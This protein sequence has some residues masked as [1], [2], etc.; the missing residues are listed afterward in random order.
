VRPPTADNPASSLDVLDL[1]TDDDAMNLVED[2]DDS[3]YEWAAAQ[4]DGAAQGAGG[5][6]T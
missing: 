1:V 3:F 6:T 2:N 5:A 4:A